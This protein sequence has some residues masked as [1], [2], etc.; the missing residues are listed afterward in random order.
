MLYS[1]SGDYGKELAERHLIRRHRLRLRHRGRLHHQG[2][3][4]LQGRRGLGL[5]SAALGSSAVMEASPADGASLTHGENYLTQYMPEGLRKVV[6]AP[7][8]KDKKPR[9]AGDGDVRQRFR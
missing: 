3:G 6:G 4:G 1:M 2:L 9:K 8:E 5:T 7:L